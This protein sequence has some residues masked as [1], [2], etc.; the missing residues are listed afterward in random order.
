MQKGQTKKKPANRQL[1]ISIQNLKF[2]LNVNAIAPL[3]TAI[4]TASE[5]ALESRSTRYTLQAIGQHL[6][7]AGLNRYH[8]FIEDIY[9]YL[10]YIYR[11]RA[12]WPIQ[13]V[14]A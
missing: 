14:R 4:P 2:N 9:L 1:F 6:R 12:K 11:N 7:F 10:Y 5:G 3:R 13:I 8:G